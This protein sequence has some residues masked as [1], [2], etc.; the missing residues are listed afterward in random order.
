MMRSSGQLHMK[1]LLEGEF[2]FHMEE[3]ETTL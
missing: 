1:E 3:D 2:L